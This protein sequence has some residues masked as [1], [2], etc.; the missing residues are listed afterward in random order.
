MKHQVV[1]C[2]AVCSCAPLCTC[3]SSTTG[4]AIVAYA[5]VGPSHDHARALFSLD[6]TPSLCISSFSFEVVV[7]DRS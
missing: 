2:L 4:Q 7:P 1:D 5:R 6:S 3:G